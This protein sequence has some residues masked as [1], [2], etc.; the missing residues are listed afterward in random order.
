MER[1]ERRCSDDDDEED[2]RIHSVSPG[3]LQENRVQVIPLQRLIVREVAM[4]E[5]AMYLIYVSASAMPEM[6]ELHSSSK[7]ECLRWMALI[8]QAV[9]R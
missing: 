9:D 7:D 2:G 6:Y 1:I 3:L 5:K 4:E 8:R